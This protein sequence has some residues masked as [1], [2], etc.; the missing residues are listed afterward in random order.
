MTWSVSKLAEFWG[1]RH[2]WKQISTRQTDIGIF[3]PTFLGREADGF[4]KRAPGESTAR[5][6]ETTVD[7]KRTSVYRSLSRASKLAAPSFNATS[8][9]S[10]PNFALV[11]MQYSRLRRS[12][13]RDFNISGKKRKYSAT[14][15][16]GRESIEK[17]ARHRF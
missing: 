1:R 8:R 16:R 17:L 3:L 6:W 11:R 4:T 14:R 15:I 10:P 2:G 5:V 13:L 9:I 7:N 12:L